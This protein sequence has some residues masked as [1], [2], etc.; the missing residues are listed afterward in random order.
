MANNLSGVVKR[1][2][3]EVYEEIFLKK[4]IEQAVPWCKELLVYVT[5]TVNEKRKERKQEALKRQRKPEILP[6]AELDSIELGEH[7]RLDAEI[8]FDTVRITGALKKHLEFIEN[9][10]SKIKIKD[11]QT[12]RGIKDVYI[13]LD[14]YLTPTNLHVDE[15]DKKN[16]RPIHDALFNHTDHC[17]VLGQ[18]GAGKTTSM[19]KI[20]STFFEKEKNKEKRKIP[21]LIPFRSL[22]IQQKKFPITSYLSGIIPHTLRLKNAKIENN[23]GA[24]DDIETDILLALLDKIDAIIILDGFDEIP[25]QENKYVVLNEVQKM[26]STIRA[27]KIILTCRSGEFNYELEKAR[28]FEIAPLSER[29]ISKF[30]NK[31]IN[32]PNSPAE[33]LQ[34]I[35]RS[36]FSDTSIKPLFLAYLCAVYERTGRIPEKPHTVYRRVVE[37]LLEEWDEQRLIRRETAY[38]EFEVDRKSAFL[39]HMAY[40]LTVSTKTP[41]FDARALESTY[42]KICQNF[43]LPVREYKKVAREIE[44]HTGLLIESGYKTYSFSHKSLQEYLT[45]QYIVKLPNLTSIKKDSEL[46]GAELAIATSISSNPSLYFAEIILFLFEDRAMTRS[47]YDAFLSRLKIEKPVFVTCE[48]IVLALASLWAIRGDHSRYLSWFKEIFKKSKPSTLFKYYRIES[49][50][51]SNTKGLADARGNLI[52]RRIRHHSNHHLKEQLEFSDMEIIELIESAVPNTQ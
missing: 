40:E 35:K 33:F 46:L 43:G 47:F 16:I 17:I 49:F 19:Q 10:S 11:M 25:T 26:F 21:F 39:S 32:P 30:A 41:E 1:E 2:L 8:D 3:S 7:E 51:E 31:W 15:L 42:R 44:S 52:L 23:P 13:E 29:Q 12:P 37:L 36:P 48:N 50:V 18:P 9:W 28:T 24:T 14:T 4:L 45:A 34:S 5:Q 27:S 6:E 38:S 20:C 22:E